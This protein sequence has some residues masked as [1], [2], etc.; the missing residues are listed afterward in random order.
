[1][2]RD[3]NDEALARILSNEDEVIPSSGFASSV[4]DAVRAEAAQPAPI[5]FPWKWALPGFAVCVGL[6]VYSVIR[7]VEIGITSGSKLGVGP[8]FDRLLSIATPGWL[9]APIGMSIEWSVL[10][11]LVSFFSVWLAMRLAVGRE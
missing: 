9:K 3:R 8:S 4:M 5:P 6:I 10:A 2:N 11:L 7:L 1:M